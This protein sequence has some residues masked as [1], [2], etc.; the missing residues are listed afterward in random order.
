[1]LKNPHAHAF[2]YAF[3]LRPA[4]LRYSDGA[5]EIITLRPNALCVA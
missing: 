2:R 1:M 4:L 5:I 3:T